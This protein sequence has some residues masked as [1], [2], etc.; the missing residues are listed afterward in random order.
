MSANDYYHSSSQPQT[1]YPYPHAPSSYAA[2]PYHS[3]SSTPA[4]PYSEPAHAGRPSHQTPGSP[5]ETPFDDHVYPL[6]PRQSSNA[7]MA[8]QQQQQPSRYNQDTG[9]YGQGRLSPDERRTEDIP[10]Q[11]RPPAKDANGADHVYDMGESG[12][13]SRNSRKSKRGTVRLGELGM[14][15]SKKK[16]IPWVVYFFSVVQIAVFIGEI[17]RNGMAYPAKW[18]RFMR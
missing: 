17:I 6:D 5:F 12:R 18:S 4:P 14:I 3:Q 2:A 1:G 7:N 9:Y 8:Q 15:G 10:L 13:S 16:R 11:D